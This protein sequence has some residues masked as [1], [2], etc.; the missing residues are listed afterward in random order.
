M[1]AT[2]APFNLLV[3]MNRPIEQ[4]FP[5][6]RYVIVRRRKLKEA[7]A[8]TIAN[9]GVGYESDSEEELR[10][11]LNDE[12]TRAAALDEKTF[13]MTLSLTFGLTVLGTLSPL[14]LDHINSRCLRLM[15]G[16]MIIVAVAYALAGGFV[17]L[18]AMRTLPMYVA[19]L[20]S[21]PKDQI[22]ARRSKVA[23][24]LH[25][26]ELISIVRQLRNETSYL[27]LRNGF[28]FLSIALSIFI[29]GLA[30]GNVGSTMGSKPDI[31]CMAAG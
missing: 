4:I 11:L 10:G 16:V 2:H 28:I 26:N 25:R 18:G 8:C 23:E 27:S 21:I 5:F 20:G 14:L 7:M 9:V 19:R 29:V 17:A 15:C 31:T 24:Y 30:T 22:E 1:S 13:K 6:I 3:A 12:R